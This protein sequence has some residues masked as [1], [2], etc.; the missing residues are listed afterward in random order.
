ME[1]SPSSL[2]FSVQWICPIPFRFAAGTKEHV[3]IQEEQLA[4]PARR[5]RLGINNR[6]NVN[7]TPVNVNQHI[8]VGIETSAFSG[9]TLLAFLLNAHPQIASIGEMDGL[10]R[11]N[12]E[13]YVC[14]CGTLIQSCEFWQAMRHEMAKWGV[15]FDVADFV[16]RFHF[17]GPRWFQRL[18][19]DS[20]HNRT[21]DALRDAMLQSFPRERRRFEQ[22]VARNKTFVESVLQLTGKQIFVDTSKD[23]LRARA[24][25]M[26]SDYD[27]RVIHL[28]RDPRGVIASRLRRHPDLPINQ[29]AQEWVWLHS[30]LEDFRRYLTPAKYLRLR[31]EDLCREPRATTQELYRFCGADASFEMP[32]LKSTAHHIVGNPM[33]LN[34]VSVIR[35]DESWRESLTIEQQTEIWQITKKLSMQYGYAWDGNKY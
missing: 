7:V 18:R 25:K 9:A 30:R 1:H 35:L 22:I 23:R 33:R 31:Y 16:T 29:A 17:G 26:F 2:D 12:P 15:E 24:L 4:S 14:S 11:K 27:V 21:F 28:I 32:D 5:Q 3:I 19:T 10:L 8:F 6:K 13:D 34:S 20:F